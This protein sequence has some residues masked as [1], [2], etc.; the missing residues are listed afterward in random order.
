MSRLLARSFCGRAGCRSFRDVLRP[1]RP[2]CFPSDLW[3]SR[4]RSLPWGPN[5]SAVRWLR[6]G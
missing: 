2:A 6:W 5:L 1:R 3:G 4:G